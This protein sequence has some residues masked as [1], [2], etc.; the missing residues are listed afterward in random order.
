[1]IELRSAGATGADQDSRWWRSVPGSTRNASST[2]TALEKFDWR[3]QPTLISWRDQTAANYVDRQPRCCGAVGLRKQCSSAAA[4]TPLTASGNIRDDTEDLSPDNRSARAIYS[5]TALCRL[6]AY[7][8][9]ASGGSGFSQSGN[10]Y[11]DTA[12]TANP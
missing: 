8:A 2:V 6:S 3:A 10:I 4:T 5:K 9:S 1:M 11:D 7:D 12:A